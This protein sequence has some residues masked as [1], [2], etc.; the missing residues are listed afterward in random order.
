MVEYTRI[1]FYKNMVTKKQ[2]EIGIS[3]NRKWAESFLYPYNG[4]FSSYYKANVIC[5]Y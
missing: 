5:M 1:F 2:S 3:F 4:K